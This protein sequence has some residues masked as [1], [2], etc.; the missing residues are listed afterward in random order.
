VHDQYAG[1]GYFRETEHDQCQRG[2]LDEIGMRPDGL[3]E[4][5]HATVAGIDTAADPIRDHIDG[6][7][8]AEK[9]EHG[10]VEGGVQKDGRIHG[11]A[12]VLS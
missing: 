7:D 8:C 6:E 2:L 11:R 1:A 4:L 3:G 9:S 5:G 10:R 12:P